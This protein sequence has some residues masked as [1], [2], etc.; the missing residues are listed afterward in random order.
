MS[1]QLTDGKSALRT[2]LIPEEWRVIPSYPDYAASSHGRIRRE[3]S[4]SP[5]SIAG[6]VL[7]PCI[8][9]RW[10]AY[11][12]V[13][14]WDWKTQTG[15]TVN[16]QNLVAEAF[17]GPRPAGMEINHKSGVKTD[18]SVANIEYVTKRANE[19]HA[20]ANRLHPGG[21]RH[22]ASK[23]TEMQV[24]EIRS[25]PHATER[26]LAARYGVA[27]T[28]IHSIRVRHTWKYVA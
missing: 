18:N 28:T 26:V 9:G 25:L 13:R 14:L 10:K 19:D 8:A 2:L 1:D 20:I 24:R 16:V 3:V 4:R 7:T 23:L 6:R 5:Q 12:G 15:K 27:S 11:L 21:E 22:H 17:L